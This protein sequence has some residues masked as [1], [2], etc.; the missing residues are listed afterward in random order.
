MI[1]SCISM[2]RGID[3]SNWIKSKKV[4]VGA[5]ILIL[6]MLVAFYGF[7][8]GVEK[9]REQEQ[10]Q[11]KEAFDISIKFFLGDKKG[12]DSKKATVADYFME[13][14]FSDEV[15]SSGNITK[16]G[17]RK[18]VNNEGIIPVIYEYG[19][20]SNK[21]NNCIYFYLKDNDDKII[22]KPIIRIITDLP[23]RL[24]HKQNI[25]E[26][27]SV[28]Y[29]LS[30]VMLCAKTYNQRPCTQGIK[31]EDNFYTGD[32]IYF[33]ICYM[34]AVI[35]SDVNPLN[36]PDMDYC[37]NNK[38]NR[39]EEY[40][41]A[42]SHCKEESYYERVWF[43]KEWQNVGIYLNDQLVHNIEIYFEE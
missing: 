41:N 2:F 34:G 24:D 37:I 32:V 6:V 19:N 8:N 12:I 5:V 23:F 31:F 1:K 39:G 9:E 10:E 15:S 36:P 11:V 22:Y 7:K 3:I 35:D 29:E 30:D 18:A 20:E 26:K 25:D 42:F 13:D 38:I 27:K 16:F 33:D 43:D 40:N 17:A 14:K 28:D 4:I 21:N